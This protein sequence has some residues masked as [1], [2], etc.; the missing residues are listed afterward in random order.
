MAVNCYWGMWGACAAAV[1]YPATLQLQGTQQRPTRLLTAQALRHHMSLLR[2]D[3]AR[4]EQFL[5]LFFPCGDFGKLARPASG[6]GRGCASRIPS[7]V[8]RDGNGYPSPAYP[9]GKYPLDIQ[10]WDKK[11][12]MGIQMGKIYTHRVERV[13]VWDPKT[14]TRIPRY[15]DTHLIV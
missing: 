10:V 15:P 1:M 11:I 8:D 4:L 6:T 9:P 3:R 14:H 2:R 12:P 5:F 13:W 7:D